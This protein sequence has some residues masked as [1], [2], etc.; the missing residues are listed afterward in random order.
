MGVKNM[1]NLEKKYK[2]LLWEVQNNDFYKQ[3]MIGKVNCYVCNSCKAVTKSVNK[4]AG[5]IPFMIVCSCGNFAQST[6]FKDIAPDKKP[7]IEFYR[8][9]LEELSKLNEAEVTHVLKGG[10]I[11]KEIE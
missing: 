9:T 6:F 2:K 1:S 4:D 5:V 3:P 10:L 8:P 7:K 11:E